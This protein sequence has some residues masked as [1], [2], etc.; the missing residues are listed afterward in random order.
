MKGMNAPL[1]T[2]KLE[3]P[4]KWT[5]YDSYLV[6]RG[7]ADICFPSDFQYLQHA[8]QEITAQPCSIYKNKDFV[9]MFALEAWAT[10]KNNYN[11]LREEYVNT[12][13]LVTEYA[14]GYG[15]QQPITGPKQI[16]FKK[17]KNK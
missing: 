7:A 12:S 15:T 11:P 3:D 4:T 17:A 16:N 14:R 9:D 6:P 10:T 1:V 5:N 8:Y 13:F 2:D